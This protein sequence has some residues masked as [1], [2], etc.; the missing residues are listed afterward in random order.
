MCSWCWGFSPVI[1]NISKTY[2]DEAP[3]SIVLGGLHAF[4]TEPMN[5]GYKSTIRHHWEDVGH[6]VM[7]DAPERLL[8]AMDR[9]LD[10]DTAPENGVADAV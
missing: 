2:A 7:E 5:E 10:R 1:K 8:E 9:F 4:D 3:V 6:Y